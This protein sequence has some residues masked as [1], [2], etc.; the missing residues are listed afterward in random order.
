MKNSKEHKERHTSA[1]RLLAWI[2]LIMLVCC[3]TATLVCALTGK[4]TSVILALLFIDMSVPVFFYLLHWVAKL[5]GQV[6]DSK[7]D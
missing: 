5:L 4:S 7:K 2:M 3:I 1:R 6:R